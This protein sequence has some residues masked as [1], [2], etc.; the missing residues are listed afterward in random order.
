MRYRSR[1]AIAIVSLLFA[2]CGVGRNYPPVGSYSNV[3]IVTDAGRVEDTVTEAIVREIQH[4]IDYYT[5]VELQFRVRLVPAAD[6]ERERPT[7][8]MLICGVVR[9]GEIGGIIESFIGTAG[10]R[11][12]LEGKNRIFR[13]MDYPV[14]GQYTI[15]VTASSRD[16]LLETI[17]RNGAVLRDLIEEGNRL[18]LRDFLLERENE[19]LSEELAARYGFSLRV[20]HLYELNRDW[21]DAPGVELVRTPPHRG[22]TVSWTPWTGRG[23]SVA[24]STALYEARGAMAWKMYDRDVMRPDLVF[25]KEGSLGD[26]D[27]VVMRGYW[28][29]SEKLY[30][31]PFLC[32]FVHDRVASR[33]WIVDCLVYAP[34]EDKHVFIRE[35]HAVAETFSIR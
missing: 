25:W 9:D 33:L 13:K 17:E 4:E 2:G 1:I 7:K 27:A 3:V 14:K 28:E 11:R 5:R 15:I 23:L 30:G 16:I 8:N 10:V 12:V 26:Y 6:F 20:P 22:L 34:T 29:N 32:F 18:R 21:P 31:G 35:L 24:D 19:D